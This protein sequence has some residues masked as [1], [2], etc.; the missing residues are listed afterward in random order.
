MKVQSRVLVTDTTM[1]DAHQSLLATG[2]EPTICCAA[3]NCLCDGLAATVLAG[4][5]GRR[6]LRRRDAVSERRTLGASRRYPREG[7]EH[8][9]PDAAARRQRRGLH[10]LSRQCRAPFRWP[11]GAGAAWTCS[12]SSIASTGSRTCAS[13]STRCCEAGKLAEGAICYTGDMLDPARDQIFALILCRPRQGA[14]A[15]RLPYPR[16]QGHGGRAEARGGA[17]ARQGAEGRGRPAHPLPYPRH[18]GHRGRDRAGRGRSRRRRVDAAMDAMSGR[19]S[20]PCLGSIVEALRQ[21]SATPG[22]TRRRSA[23]SLLLGGG[24]RAIRR[25]RERSQGGRVRGLSARDAR[26]AVHQ[27]EGAGALA[28]ARDPLARSGEGLSATPTTCSATSSR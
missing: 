7:A 19:T 8:S 14:R 12:A 13:R 26:R 2:C 10:Q 17:R 11:R 16:H 27:S 1:R 9:D 22:S 28:R 15:R 5:L 24:A 23:R 18:L 25:V 3:A 20:Q 6:D 21:P 4:M